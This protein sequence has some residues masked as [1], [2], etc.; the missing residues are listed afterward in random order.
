MSIKRLPTRYIALIVSTVA[1]AL[2]MIG[3]AGGSPPNLPPGIQQPAFD[4][5]RPVAN[6]DLPPIESLATA[7]GAQS[8]NL[9]G[10]WTVTIDRDN[11]T[12]EIIPVRQGMYHFNVTKFIDGP[13]LSLG[14]TINGGESDPSN[15]LIDCMVTLTNPFDSSLT[16]LCGFDVRGIL[17]TQGGTSIGGLRVA[18]SGETRLLNA[19]SHTRWWNPTEFPGT[20]LLAFT[21]GALAP[22]DYSSL[23]ATL[24]PYKYFA[25]SL[26]PDYPVRMVFDPSVLP[27][28]KRGIFKAGESNTRRYKIQFPSDGSGFDLVFNYGVDVS[29]AAPTVKPP[30]NLPDDFPIA[31]NS[32]EPFLV[33]V[34]TTCNTLWYASA[35]DRGGE[36]FLNIRVSDWQGKAG[37]NIRGEVDQI[38]VQCPGVFAG[39][40]LAEWRWEDEDYAH[41]F[42]DVGDYGLPAGAGVYPLLVSVVS[43]SG[44]YDQGFPT[45]FPAGP[46]TAYALIDIS[47]ATAA[48]EP[49]T[50]PYADDMG[51]NT[52]PFW[53][54]ENGPGHSPPGGSQWDYHTDHWG[55]CDSL[56]DTYEKSMDTYLVGP[57]LLV[58]LSGSLTVRYLRA[59]QAESAGGVAGGQ[60]VYRINGGAWQQMG[61]F[62]SN[63][64]GLDGSDPI[65]ATGQN[66]SLTGLTPLDTIEIGFHFLSDSNAQDGFGYHV[67]RMVVQEYPAIVV[68][69]TDFPQFLSNAGLSYMYQTIMTNASPLAGHNW[70]IGLDWHNPGLFLDALEGGDTMLVTFPA[71]GKFWVSVNCYLHTP[72]EFLASGVAADVDVYSY[73]PDAGAFFS[74]DFTDNSNGWDLTTGGDVNGD[75]MQIRGDGSGCLDNRQGVSGC[76]GETSDGSPTVLPEKIAWVSVPIP[77]AAGDG[78]KTYIRLFH[79]FWLNPWDSVLVRLNGN[80]YPTG[81]GLHYQAFSPYLSNYAW[82][83][84]DS[85]QAPKLEVQESVICLGDAFNGST[86]TLQLVSAPTNDFTNCYTDS[87]TF[88]WQVDYI[89]LFQTSD[90]ACFFHEDFNRGIVWSE[91][92]T[93]PY[94]LTIGADANGNF[95]NVVPDDGAGYLTN[96]QVA[97]GCW[98]AS[99]PAD[100]SDKQA[101]IFAF[102][103]HT[104][105]PIELSIRHQFNVENEGEKIG[106]AV[107][108]IAV[109]PD[110]GFIYNGAGDYW[111]GSSGGWVISHFSLPAH[112]APGAMTQISF[113]TSSAD[114]IDNCLPSG[115]SGWQIDWIDV[116]G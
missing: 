77:G 14:V 59:M 107:G 33:E 5:G 87:Y 36:L 32:I 34:D 31:A 65:P 66:P 61:Q 75:F 78:A 20:G 62:F 91:S 114:E 3:C 51:T 53:S 106:I 92:Y 108:G 22:Y 115:Y 100:V 93:Y 109:N 2:L 97:T 28:Q 64:Y 80:Q 105:G 99:T 58:P 43:I 57:Q 15:G 45:S 6:P 103:P 40:L 49:F 23:T 60:T 86:K 30:V 42:V 98:N 48:I 90:P 79:R 7:E 19:D 110:G 9:A 81:Y 104:L 67:Y 102:I 85:I 74:D 46:V 37:A 38:R 24:N 39:T 112:P 4:A 55:V 29:W 21:P 95:W 89:E 1:A 41:Y 113:F 116:S 16:S 50:L 73:T 12:A 83:W 71:E 70:W 72:V 56:S 10:I 26:E 27:D 76:Y 111:T 94:D 52:I 82:G 84:F 63:A 47:V 11:L 18:S 8:H 54:V 96:V 44:S 88:G 17:F 68:E 101:R 25:D 69:K 35:S 13:P